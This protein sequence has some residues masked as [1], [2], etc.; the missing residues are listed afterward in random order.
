[1][2]LKATFFILAGCVDKSPDYITWPQ[3]RQMVATGHQV[4]SHGWCHRMLTQCS[5]RDLQEELVSSKRELE[6]R[7]G[8]PV[9]SLSMPGG[10]WNDH[11]IDA[12]ASAGYK[13][14]FHSNPWAKSKV[15]HGVRVRGRFTVTN[16]M[17]APSLRNQ[18]QIGAPRR[19]YLGTRYAA[20]E[21]VRAMLGDRLYHS[22]WRRFVHFNP[23][24]GMELHVGGDTGE[25]GSA[26]H[27]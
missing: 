12:C 26:S 16:R 4:Q 9:S 20:K 2:G 19:F 18:L 11:V 25:A 22:L 3:A 5:P 27:T 24:D 13:A 21:Q 8:V 14:V 10:R 23:D 1:M 17:D 7:L 15:L 6:D